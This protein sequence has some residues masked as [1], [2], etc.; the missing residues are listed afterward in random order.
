MDAINTPKKGKSPGI[1]NILCELIKH[2]GNCVVK[3]LTV[4]CQKA[5]T[6]KS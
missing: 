3:I 6:S 1:D 5:L 2:R 4:M